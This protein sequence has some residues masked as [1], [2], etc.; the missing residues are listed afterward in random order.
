MR[1]IS[2][3]IIKMKFI[4]GG[5]IRNKSCWKLL[6]PKNLDFTNFT[7]NVKKCMF[8]FSGFTKEK[9]WNSNLNHFQQLLFHTFPLPMNFIFM[10]L[11]LMSRI[12]RNF[13]GSIFTGN[14]MLDNSDMRRNCR[15]NYISFQK[16]YCLIDNFG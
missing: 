2:T 10:I 5:K 4:G 6:W 14:K 15:L 1:G 12:L 7:N 11:V 16:V 9:K 3:N 8:N 13:Y